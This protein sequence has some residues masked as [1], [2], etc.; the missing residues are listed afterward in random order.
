MVHMFINR[1]EEL[2]FLEELHQQE[3]AKLLVLYG[4]RRIGK[5]ELLNE[6]AKRH[7]ALYFLARQESCHDQL[8]KMSTEIAEFFDD[9]VLRH[10]PFRNYDALFTYLAR[11]DTPVFFDEF[12]YLVESNASLPSILQEY[13]DKLFSKKRM[14]IILC[15]SSISMMESLLGY[16]SPLYGRR[17]EQMLLEPLEF[18]DAALFFPEL[19]PEDKIANYAVLGGT[20]AYLLEFDYSKTLLTNIRENI[21]KKNKF[22]YQDTLFVLQQELH[23]PRIYYSII[24]SIAKGNAKLGQI[25]NDTGIE[26]SK[27]TKYLSVLR[28]LHIIERRVPITEKNPEKSRK[29]IY[30]LKD[31]YFKF[32]FR[33][34]FANTEYIE[35]NRQDKLINERISPLLN[36]FVGQAY[37]DIAMDYMKKQKMFDNYI[38]G[39]WWDKNEEIDIIGIDHMSN[40]IMLGEV[41]WKDLTEKQAKQILHHLEQKAS[42]VKWGNKPERNYTLI[43][44]H[45]ENKEQLMRQ[46]YFVF[47]IDDIVE[48]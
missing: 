43:G 47:D 38:F 22:L 33:F 28:N 10:N 2:K 39:R 20:P 46:G 25:I 4:K 13:W 1:K 12:P 41:K 44:K 23:E 7:S 36:T 37:E 18:K 15:G 21:L 34:I 27:I 30:L 45:V 26:K 35:Q 24:S 19:A 48:Q 32:W 40:M 8:R 29:G 17:T 6:F 9:D 42:K 11:K 3:Q 31:N 16:R 5:T 14:F